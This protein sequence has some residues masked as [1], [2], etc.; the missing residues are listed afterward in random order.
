MG[1]GGNGTQGHRTGC[2]AFHNFFGRLD[3]IERNGFIGID[4]ELK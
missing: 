4:L 2:K 1:L 3:F